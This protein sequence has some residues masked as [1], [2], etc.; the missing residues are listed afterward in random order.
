MRARRCKDCESQRQE[1]VACE[2][3]GR[4]IESLVNGWSSPPHVVVIHGWKVIMNERIAVN[5]FQRDGRIQSKIGTHSKQARTFDD[6]ER[7]KPLS[8]AE[9]PMSHGLK[10]PFGNR[11]K[12]LLPQPFVEMTFNTACMGF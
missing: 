5:A 9:R 3:G 10:Q 1:G 11:A 12:A 4:F 2:N 7:A 8:A 6:E